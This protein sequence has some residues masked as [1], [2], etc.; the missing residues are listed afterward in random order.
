MKMHPKVNKIVVYLYANCAH[1]VFL[2]QKEFGKNLL[3][4]VY[5]CK[6]HAFE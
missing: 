4:K 2:L 3:N 6:K 5:Q 1:S